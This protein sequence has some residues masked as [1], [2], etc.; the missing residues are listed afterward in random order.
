[1]RFYQ[2]PPDTRDKEKIFGGIFTFSQFAF[3]VIGVIFGAVSG[4]LV[5]SVFQNII[6]LVVVFVFGILIF[7]PF[8]FIK[9]SKLGDMELFRYVLLQWA[10]RKRVKHMAHVNINHGGE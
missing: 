2:V 1:M 8:A 3:L 10:Y 6:V 7:L 4:L 5:Y 9:I